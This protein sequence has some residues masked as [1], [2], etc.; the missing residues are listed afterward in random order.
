MNYKKAFKYNQDDQEFFSLILS[1]KD[2]LQISKVLEYGK[3]GIYGY[4]RA[5]NPKHLKDIKKGIIENQKNDHHSKNIISPTSIVL[6]INRSDFDQIKIKDL[7]E[8]IIEI[9]IWNIE[10]KFRII[11]GQHRLAAFK[12]AMEDNCRIGDTQFNVVVI[13]VEDNRRIVEVKTFCNINSKAKPLKMDLTILAEYNYELIERPEYIEIERHIAIQIAFMLNENTYENNNIWQNGIK[14]DINTTKAMGIIGFKSFYESIKPICTNLINKHDNKVRDLKT[15]EE[16]M[17]LIN[18][19]ANQIKEEILD[20]YW[21]IIERKWSNCFKKDLVFYNSDEY[22]IYYTNEFYIQKNMGVKALHIL[23]KD[24]LDK[25]D[26]KIEYSM[27]S[28]EQIINISKV[29]ERDWSKG[30]RFSGLS[31]EAGFKKISQIIKGD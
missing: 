4:Q 6:G 12:L 20:K 21:S 2:L 22:T 28:L 10:N 30:G 1:L 16:K 13:I 25:N 27:R 9:D 31:S 23:L 8:E 29:T 7:D 19:V 17:Q 5:V 24:I 14:L 15:Y 18:N 3:D 26:Y 11:D